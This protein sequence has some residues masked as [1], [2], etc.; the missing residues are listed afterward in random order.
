MGQPDECRDSRS[1]KQHNLQ[2]QLRPRCPG[3][4]KRAGDFF[5]ELVLKLGI[6]T[7]QEK[8]LHMHLRNTSQDDFVRPCAILICSNLRLPCV[9]R[10]GC[11]VQEERPGRVGGCDQ[12]ASARQRALSWGASWSSWT[13]AP[14]GRTHTG[15]RPIPV[16]V[17]RCESDRVKIKGQ[18]AGSR[19]NV[20]S[21]GTATLHRQDLQGARVEPAEEVRHLTRT[22]GEPLRPLRLGA[23][24]HVPP[25]SLLTAARALVAV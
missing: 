6:T 17:C 2:S 22:C 5:C 9:L 15:T 14:E 11:L 13:A 18:G 7:S 19:P 4:R 12:I 25:G 20:E 1:C 10:A 24:A 23:R 21:A 3:A 16:A 8:A